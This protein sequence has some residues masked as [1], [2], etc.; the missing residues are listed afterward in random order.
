MAG[1]AAGYTTSN[2]DDGKELY[3]NFP[4][5]FARA[6][7]NAG[8]DLVTT[9]NNHVLDKGT[10]GVLRTLNV[11]D[12]TGLDHTGSY[13]NDTEK[14]NERVKLV[15]RDGIRMAILSYTYGSNYYDFAE[16][17][18]GG[19]SYV[20]SVIS[21]TEGELFEKLK[22][23]VE[24][25]FEE[26]KKLSPALIIVL[27]HIGTQFSNAPDREQ[28]VRFGILRSAV[29]TSYLAITLTPLSLSLLR[30]MTGEMYSPHTAREISPTYTA[31]IRAT[32]VC[33]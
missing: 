13:R 11:L 16:L 27:P 2:F 15:E 17:A 33:S 7:K 23:Q 1:E 24:L 6:V 18:E 9:A 21:G 30:S 10:E 28:E 3:L 25:D 4:D 26:T 20:T 31:N 29:P 5:E 19:L 22:A 14:E 32:P 12:E 8:F